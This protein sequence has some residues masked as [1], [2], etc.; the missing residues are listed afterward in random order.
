MKRLVG[1]TLSL[2]LLWGLSSTIVQATGG[3]LSTRAIQVLDNMFVQN[4]VG[5]GAPSASSAPFTCSSTTIRSTYYDTTTNLTYFCNG[6]TWTPTGTPD[7]RSNLI[8]YEDFLSGTTTTGQIGSHGFPFVALAT[9]TFTQVAATAQNPGLVR[10][11]SHATNDNSGII[12]Y[13]TNA[14]VPASAIDT[15]LW[16]TKNWL[17]DA[18]VI[19][20]S[21]GTAITSTSL[22]VGLAPLITEM[23]ANSTSGVWI[24]RDSDLSETA[25]KFVV[26]NASGA[27]GCNSAA[28]AANVKVSTSTITPSAGTAYRFRIRHAVSGVGGV[29]TIYMRVNDEVEQ[30]FCSSG[31]DDTQGTYAAVDYH[32]FI[33]Y[34]TRTTTSVLSADVDY[35]Y[36]NIP[37]LTRY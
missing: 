36:L 12:L 7:P 27:T 28:D 35:M 34:V 8:L 9:G 26:C 3:R 33:Q 1:I 18:V 2:G 15:T 16:T 22:H 23:A 13:T 6:V 37:G 17:I 25:F 4:G 32:F 10:L 31:C 21:N 24:R 14:T 19:P 29:D 11:L 30:T 20:G 5:F